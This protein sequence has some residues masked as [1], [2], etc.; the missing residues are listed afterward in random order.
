[1]EFTKKKFQ[2]LTLVQRHK[3]CAEL[4]KK[5]Y[6]EGGKDLKIYPTLLPWMGLVDLSPLV[7]LEQ[8]AD[9]YH[10]HLQKAQLSLKEHNLLPRLRTGD[11]EPKRAFGK[12]ALYLDHVRSA[13]NIGNILR[14]VEALRFGSVYFSPKTPFVDNEKVQK[15]SMG[16]AGIVPCFQNVPLSSLPRP[17]FAIETSDSALLFP[18]EDFPESCTLILGNE[19]YGISEEVLKEVDFLVEIP[20]FG[21]KNSINIASAFA[22]VAAKKVFGSFLHAKEN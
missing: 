7:S 21:K 16:A 2:K 18:E 4:L 19:E 1:M 22:I 11:R 12:G 14:T 13:Y 6:E 3:K 15:T 20:L 9:R 10:W 8:I 5:A 17:F